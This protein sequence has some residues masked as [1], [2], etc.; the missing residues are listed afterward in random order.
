MSLETVRPKL[1]KLGKAVD[2]INKQYGRDKVRLA[3]QGYD[4]TWP[5][6]QKWL[7]RCYTTRWSDILVAS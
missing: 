3:A 4:R 5:M 6:K 7:S 2:G 1:A